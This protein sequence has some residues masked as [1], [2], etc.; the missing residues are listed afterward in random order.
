M[1]KFDLDTMSTLMERF[2]RL[3]SVIGWVRTCIYMGQRIFRI[4]KDY[5]VM[6]SKESQ[7]PLFGRR[8]TSDILAFEQIFI[9]REYSCLNDLSNVDLVIDCGANVGYSSAYFLTHFPKC[10][11]ICIEPD[12]SNFMLLEKNLAPYKERVK[13]MRAGITFIVPILKYW[14]YHTEMEVHGRFKSESVNQMRFQKYQ[15]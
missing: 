1:L 8:N 3:S 14:R 11:V 13:L 5:V 10:K 7:Y 6:L 12:S 9:E 15:Q 2:R 4:N